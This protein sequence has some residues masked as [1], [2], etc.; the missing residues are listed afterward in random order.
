V[1]H[2]G[3]TTAQSSG[4]LPACDFFVFPLCPGFLFFWKIY[5]LTF[6]QLR[7]AVRGVLPTILFFV[8]V[9][10]VQGHG[11]KVKAFAAIDSFPMCAAACKQLL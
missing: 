1:Q 9:Y 2:W 7:L 8:S 4:D 5:F 3:C 6:A 10:I 11:V